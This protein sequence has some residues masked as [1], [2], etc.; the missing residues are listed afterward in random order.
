MKRYQK[1]YCA[2][3]VILIVGVFAAAA[4]SQTGDKSKPA[5][6]GRSIAYYTK[7]ISDIALSIRENY[8]D[9]VNLDDL[10]NSSY[11]GMLANL[12]PYSVLL[13]TDDYEALREAATGRYEGIGIDIDYRDGEVT[14]ITP[15]EGAPASKLGLLP[16]DKIV[17]IEG[18]EVS[19]LTNS[20]FNDLARGKSGTSVRLT[21]ERPGVVNPMEYVVERAVVELHPVK[22]SGMLDQNVGYVRISKFA[23]KAGD[24]FESALRELKSR[25]C[26]SLI[27]DLRSNGGGLMDQAISVVSQFVPKDKLVVY[28]KGQSQSTQRRYLSTGD[29]IFPDG[30]LV[31]LVDSG[32]ASAAEIVSGAVQDLDRG[33]IMGTVT[34]GKGLVQNV[35][36][37]EGS[38]YALKLTTSKYY[39]PSGRSIQKPERSFKNGNL[40]KE[41]SKL[42]KSDP[43]VFKTNNGRKVFGGGGI[44]PDVPIVRKGLLPLEHNLSRENL[45]FQY[46]VAHTAK[47]KA[48]ARD[49]VVTD[50][51]IRDFR[52]FVRSKGFTYTSSTEELLASLESA[53]TN[54]GKSKALTAEIEAL[55]KAITRE[56]ELDF[57]RGREFIRSALRREILYIKFGDSAVYEEVITK[58]DPAVR[59]AMDVLKDRGKY[60][61]IL[62]G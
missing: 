19:R 37:W 10:F 39:I 5:R 55:R 61:S 25:G 6:G 21:I 53:A 44:T 28:T 16:G 34:Y 17:K 43:K 35:F 56:K 42:A 15:L 32:T 60:N 20:E 27:L 11:E 50:E 52:S 62:K 22:Y 58:E 8:M 54:E 31:V 30:D 51:M 24:E 36:E 13:R 45:F 2:I 46:A 18:R 38:E 3:L 14:I 33:V 49:F 57:D 59:Q 4:V 41:L 7:I 40:D 47:I 48:I 29:P 9:E 12:D 1:S 26:R 23:E